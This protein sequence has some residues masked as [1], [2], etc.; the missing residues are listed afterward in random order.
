MTADVDTMRLL[1]A[2][3]A[4]N[5]RVAEASDDDTRAAATRIVAAYTQFH[6]ERG[7]RSVEVGNQDRRARDVP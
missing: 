7:L 6:L 2:L 3:L 1:W 4:G 5:W